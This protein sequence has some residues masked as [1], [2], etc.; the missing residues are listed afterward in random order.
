MRAEV[1]KLGGILVL[2]DARCPEYQ[3]DGV[4]WRKGK[5]SVKQILFDDSNGSYRLKNHK[6]DKGVSVMRRQTWIEEGP[7]DSGLRKHEYRLVNREVFFQPES[8]GSLSRN[9]GSSLQSFPVLLHFFQKASVV[10]APRHFLTTKALRTRVW[11]QP[12]RAPGPLAVRGRH[13][14]SPPRGP[15]KR[16][17][18]AP[19]PSMGLLSQ[20]AI[21]FVKK[22]SA[23]TTLTWTRTRRTFQR[24]NLDSWMTTMTT[25]TTSMVLSGV[26][27][28]ALAGGGQARRVV[29]PWRPT[30]TTTT[31]TMVMMMMMATMLVVTTT[32]L[33][34]CRYYLAAE[35]LDLYGVPCPRQPIVLSPALCQM[36]AKAPPPPLT[37]Q[38]RQRTD[39]FIMD[40]SNFQFDDQS[41]LRVSLGAGDLDLPVFVEA[42]S[43]VNI[44]S[45]HTTCQLDAVAPDAAHLP[46]ACPG[47]WTS[48]PFSS[49]SL[50]PPPRFV[51]WHSS[52]G[53]APKA[54]PT[55]SIPA[56]LPTSRCRLRWSPTEWCR[57]SRHPTSL[58]L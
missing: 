44:L 4:E 35:P 12:L 54:P 50:S 41:L 30:T 28:V 24:R 9:E 57:L 8:D 27:K 16:Y 5:M 6:T 11:A 13:G 31:T 55:T 2:Y 21:F 25:T 17:C 1:E 7:D 18:L 29:P 40:D 53:S 48:F 47:V 23:L 43:G 3:D 33:G 37:G 45:P 42:S 34:S 32:T 51:S 49:L 39:P 15:R 36:A 14:P 38:K 56:P 26:G 19:P 58:V 52:M 20:N 46:V 22:K 10:G